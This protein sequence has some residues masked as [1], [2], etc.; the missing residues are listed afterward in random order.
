MTSRIKLAIMTSIFL[1]A[2]AF[3]GI[4][5]ALNSFSPEGLALL[6]FIVASIG[7]A[8]IY[9]RLPSKLLRSPLEIA[10]IMG[11]GVIGIGVY[12]ITLNHGELT[13]SSGIASFIAS[14]SPVISAIIAVLVLNEKM[15]MQRVAGLAISIIGVLLMSVVKENGFEW[16]PNILY[17]FLSTLAGSVYT[18]GLKAFYQKYPPVEVTALGIWGGT[19]FM[20]MTQF[21]HLQQDWQTASLFDTLTVVYL[22]LFPGVLAYICWGY[23]LSK[24]PVIRATSFLYFMPFLATLLGWLYLGETLLWQAMIGALLAIMGVFL[25]NRSYRKA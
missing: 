11:L 7:I 5:D 4:R 3:V 24:I 20:L 10:K 2:S 6:R 1:W 15:S 25:V 18:I 12:N 9:L 23:T 13:V 8:V 14:Q 16:D 19:L 17:L 22:G 21:S